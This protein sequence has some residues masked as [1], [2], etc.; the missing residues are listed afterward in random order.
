MWND[1]ATMGNSMVVPYKIKSRITISSSSPSSRIISERTENG[2]LKRY[3]YIYAHSIIIHNN[4]DVEASHQ[5]MD[6]GYPWCIHAM[7]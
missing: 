6:K 5:W 3:L 4:Q 7:K 2:I 1:A